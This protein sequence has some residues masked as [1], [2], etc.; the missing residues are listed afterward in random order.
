MSPDRQS[1]MNPYPRDPD[2]WRDIPVLMGRQ[3]AVEQRLGARDARI[4]DL[5]KAMAATRE[6]V[7]QNNERLATAVTGLKDTTDRVKLLEGIANDSRVATERAGGDLKLISKEIERQGKVQEDQGRLLESLTGESV[8][9]T[10]RQ[11]FLRSSR[12]W[13]F[14]LFGLATVI[15]SVLVARGGP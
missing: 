11:R 2:P 8:Q 9:R 5:E 3:D 13:G 1:E 15:L 6:T 14:F 12:D 4:I 10:G 7:A